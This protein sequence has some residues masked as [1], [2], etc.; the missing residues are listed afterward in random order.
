MMGFGIAVNFALAGYET[1]IYDLTDE[2]LQ[3]SVERARLALELFV[4]E[5]VISQQ[6][7]DE[8][9]GR[10]ATTTDLE[11]LAAHGNFV[12]EAIV[13]LL[14]NKQELFEALDRLCPGDTILVSNTSTFVLSDI[15]VNVRRQARIGLTHYFAPPHIVPGVEVA[16]GPDTSDETYQIV[17][18]L[19]HRTGRTPIPIQREVPGYLINRLTGALYREALRLWAEG[20]ATAE[21]IELGVKTTI[22]FRMP[23]NGPFG[24]HDISGS[25][26][27]PVPEPGTRRTLPEPSSEVLAKM[28]ARAAERRPWFLD[29][30]RVDQ[31]T[32]ER[33]RE[34]I[35][36]RQTLYGTPHYEGPGAGSR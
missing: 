18:E 14:P 4:E 19:M 30:E 31:V 5:A 22:G 25:W 26:K 13:E 28:Q 9:V 11:R 24:H 27:W 36:R 8:A 20:V 33:D 15:A 35:R 17:W 32:G 12:T 1:L 34:F 16:K 23:Y 21:D 10:I 2:T 3:Q 7:A 29:P 6:H